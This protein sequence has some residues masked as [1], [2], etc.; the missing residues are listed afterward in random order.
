MI[1]LLL[2]ACLS[3]FSAAPIPS[4]MDVEI[5]GRIR[6]TESVVR[7]RIEKRDGAVRQNETDLR[8][9]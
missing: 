6:T 7:K 9:E 5:A 1:A 4:A 3:L 2:E 8:R